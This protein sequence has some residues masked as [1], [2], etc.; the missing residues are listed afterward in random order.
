MIGGN[1]RLYTGVFQQGFQAGPG[2]GFHA[3]EP[4]PDDYPVFILQGDN[5]G[6]SSQCGEVQALFHTSHT[7]EGLAD[8]QGDS[9]TAQ[10]REGIISE[11]RI[12][13]HICFG[14]HFRRL[15]VVGDDDREAKLFGQVHFRDIGDAAVHGDQEL[16]LTGNLPDSI[17]VE[18]VSFRVAGRNA[19][20]QGS[21]FLMQYF[22]EDGGGTD[23]VGIIVS[24]DKDRLSRDNGLPEQVHGF[25]H[26]GKQEGIMEIR[27]GWIHETGGFLFRTDSAG[28]KEG[29]QPGGSIRK[30]GRRGGTAGYETSMGHQAPPF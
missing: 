22:H 3:L 11:Q 4:F 5:I 25:S 21:A 2:G 10:I 29:G 24:V 18:A 23:A 8:L 12:H 14:K 6:H 19:V 16:R 20:S 13:D 9:R 7:L 30:G 26:A 27:K 1:G 15:V 28:G 17:G